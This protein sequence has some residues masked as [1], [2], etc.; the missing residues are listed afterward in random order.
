[1]STPNADLIG[2]SLA[3]DDVKPAPVYAP[4]APGWYT[5]PA[6]R[7]STAAHYYCDAELMQSFLF[8]DGTDLLKE[9]EIK[10]FDLLERGWQLEGQ[11]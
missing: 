8:K 9:S 4:P 11:R 5:W 3:E 10:R 6:R 2:T 7:Q 1:M